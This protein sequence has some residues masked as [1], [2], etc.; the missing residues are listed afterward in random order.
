MV[1]DGFARFVIFI[2]IAGIITGL[3][4]RSKKNKGL[5]EINKT[6]KWLLENE[7]NFTKDEKIEIMKSIIDAET[8]V[9]SS[10]V[11]A[12]TAGVRKEGHTKIQN[13]VDKLSGL[14]SNFLSSNNEEFIL[15]S[16]VDDSGSKVI[17]FNSNHP[18]AT[19]YVSRLDK[20]LFLVEQKGESLTAV[21]EENRRYSLKKED[22]E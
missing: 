5:E 22:I 4:A 10:D 11:T 18:K 19:V 9:Y 13:Q 21:D 3:Y 2:I 14:R 20:V 12:P 8:Q 17:K 16:K 7:E 1:F 6:K 15:S